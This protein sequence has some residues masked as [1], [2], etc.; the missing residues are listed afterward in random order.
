MKVYTV[1]EN[2]LRLENKSFLWIDRSRAFWQLLVINTPLN[3][4]S[5]DTGI[6]RLKFVINV[7][8]STKSGVTKTNKGD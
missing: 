5:M 7:N 1:G 6:D 4:T 2:Y 8:A 3:V